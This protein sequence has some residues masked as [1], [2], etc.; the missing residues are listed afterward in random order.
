MVSDLT[1]VLSHPSIFEQVEEKK[2]R[3]QLPTDEDGNEIEAATAVDD[4]AECAARRAESQKIEVLH[5]ILNG[6]ERLNEKV[7]VFSQRIP[8]LRYLQSVCRSDNRNVFYLDGQ[9]PAGKRQ[10]LVNDFNAL[11]QPA[12]FLIGTKAGA[13][14]NIQGASR[15][16]IF[17]F[18]YAPTT[19]ETQ[20]IGRCYRMGQTKPVFVYWLTVA[21]TFEESIE[22]VSLFKLLLFDLAVDGKSSTPSSVPKKELFCQP[23]Y[24]TKRYRDNRLREIDTILDSILDDGKCKVVEVLT[25]ED[26][27][28]GRTFDCSLTGTSVQDPVVIDD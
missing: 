14:L 13:G 25:D 3:G 9:V 10:G 16:V 21:N 2:T 8:T 23:I 5:A 28:D 19:E 1:L 18:Q 12:V 15:V 6:A 4:A 17:D 7:L 26:I 11:D 27:K 20:A 24:K 22:N